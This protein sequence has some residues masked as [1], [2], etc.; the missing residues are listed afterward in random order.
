[1]DRGAWWATV[2]GV[3]TSD[4]TEGTSHGEARS[5]CREIRLQNRRRPQLTAPTP[6]GPSRGGL[7]LRL[8][9]PAQRGGPRRQRRGLRKPEVEALSPQRQR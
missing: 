6:N 3:A 7:R 4:T 1:M 9:G 8:P 2:H 5:P